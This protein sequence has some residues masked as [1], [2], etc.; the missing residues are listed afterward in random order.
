[1]LDG[2]LGRVRWRS[3]MSSA[4]TGVEEVSTT[5]TGTSLVVEELS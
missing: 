3:A 1:M 5:H 4:A 2:D